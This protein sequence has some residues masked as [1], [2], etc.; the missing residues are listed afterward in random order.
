[1]TSSAAPRASSNAASSNI[2]S[3]N[4]GQAHSGPFMLTLCQL[5]VSVSIRPPQSPQ[6]RRFT[7]FTTSAPHRDGREQVYL[8]MGYFETL[9]D[10][11][12]LLGAVRRRFPEAVAD[13]T[14]A[15]LPQR[16]VWAP[17]LHPT[18]PPPGV[19]D[20]SFAPVPSEALTDTQVM[21]V[22]ETSGAARAPARDEVEERSSAQIGMLRP[23]D[24]STRRVLKEAVAQGAPV[25]FAVQ[26]DWSPKRINPDRV[27][28]LPLFK[29]HTLY[30]TESRREGRCRFF[31]RLGFFP[32][33]ASAKEAAFS[34]RSKFASAVVVP[35]TEQEIAR[36]HEPSTESVESAP[37]YSPTDQPLD[38]SGTDSPEPAPKFVAHRL[39]RSSQTPETLEQTL[40][41]LAAQE[42][43]TDPDSLSETGVRHLK[44]EVLERESGGS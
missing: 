31:L 11:Q 37:A 10:A 26:L 33:A 6:L 24:T 39:G 21:R 12:R 44:V 23:E 2:D 30:T 9:T 20:K 42:M 13:T 8:H 22:L 40:E 28:Q 38:R 41:A 7:F 1:M 19:P 32:D 17:A 4:R 18:V 3:V 16:N 25:F 27:P 5:D 34:I 15:T 29:T 36:A 14:P 35:V 43:W